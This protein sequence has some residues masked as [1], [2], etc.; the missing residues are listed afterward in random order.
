MLAS[1]ALA[2][3]LVV[4]PHA[5]VLPR[6]GI[7]RAPPPHAALRLSSPAMTVALQANE[8]PSSSLPGVPPALPTATSNKFVNVLSG[9]WFAIT[10]LVVLILSYIP[11][12]PSVAYSMIFD[13]EQR[14]AVDFCVKLWA[15]GSLFMLGSQVRVIGA[16][17]LP[18]RGEAVVYCPNHSSFLDI[19]VLSA[20][21]PRYVQSRRL[22]PTP[23]PNR[24]DRVSGA[25]LT[26]TRTF[27]RAA[28]RPRHSLDSS[29]RPR[30]PATTLTKGA[31][32]PRPPGRPQVK[33]ISKIEILRIPLIGWA[34]Q[35][36][37]H[38]PLRR[39]DR[40]SQ[41]ETFREAVASLQAGNSL[42]AFP[43]GTRSKDGRVIN[44]KKG[45]FTMASKAGVRVVPISIV[46]THVFQ[47]TGAVVPL[48]PPRG[49]TIVCHP[50]LAV[51]GVKKEQASTDECRAT[52]I[53][54]LPSEMQPRAAE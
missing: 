53:S 27:T 33:Y 37:R 4:A 38:I 48:A 28:S 9:V 51:P 14:R 23:S 40:K 47:P 32:R 19:F 12:L 15:R 31:H 10:S 1:V 25:T 41:M 7:V 29:S 39:S 50:P 34:M 21:L 16:E 30:A 26:L 49:L 43:E 44:F 3:G 18:P 36:A 8:L 2:A 24:L 42:I 35:F 11:L 5:H 52:V 20:Y 54:A 13:R 45:P 22:D 6:G 17:S 46:G